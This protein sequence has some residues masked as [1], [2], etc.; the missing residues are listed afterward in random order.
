MKTLL[1]N[2]EKNL[3][4]RVQEVYSWD[5]VAE[6]ISDLYEDILEGKEVRTDVYEKK[7]EIKG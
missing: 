5:K 3:L 7:I 6:A 1:R 4:K 2:I